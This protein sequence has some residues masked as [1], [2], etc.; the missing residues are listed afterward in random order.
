LSK[1]VTS[2]VLA[3]SPGP[4]GA[5]SLDPYGQLIKLLV[6]AALTIVILR[7][8]VRCIWSSGNPDDSTPTRRC[9]TLQ[10]SELVRREGGFHGFAE[11]LSAG[12]TAYV[13]RL[14]TTTDDDL[15]CVWLVCRNESGRPRDF[16]S[17]HG[18]LRTRAAMPRTG[19]R[20]S[21]SNIGELQRSLVV[22]DRDLELLLGAAQDEAEGADTQA[23]FT[24]LVQGCVD[25]LGCAVGA[26]LI[27]TRTSRSAV[28]ARCGT[29][30]GHRRALAHAPPPDRLDAAA[31]PDHDVEPRARVWRARGPAVQDSL[32]PVMHGGQRVLGVLVL[33]QAVARA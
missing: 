27:P 5:T 12:R 15:G 25:H 7:S 18:L 31:S 33:F 20:S 30:R 22:R 9:S 11:L 28:P 8:D 17:M 4:I 6:P 1:H 26:L 32:L 2:A 21:Q 19:A 14:R 3:E 24:R 16:E 29:A 23:D 10:A 13:L